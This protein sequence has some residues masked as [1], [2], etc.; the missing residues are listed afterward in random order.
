[1]KAVA[2]ILGLQAY[3]MH[4]SLKSPNM[5]GSAVGRF[6]SM[7][8]PQVWQARWVLWLQVQLR[9]LFGLDR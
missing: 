4:I 9:M 6:A 3:S 5:K 1:M 7:I 2:R 8:N